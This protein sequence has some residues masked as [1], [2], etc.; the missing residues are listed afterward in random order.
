[1]A[2]RD[3]EA[4]RAAAVVCDALDRA[5]R[6]IRVAAKAKGRV[7]QIPDPTV[8]VAAAIP[9]TAIRGRLASVLVFVRYSHQDTGQGRLQLVY[10]GLTPRVAIDS[11]K[12]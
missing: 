1:V 3:P 12:F 11:E 10:V 6:I 9:T 4:G 5:A 2:G 8:A 7:V